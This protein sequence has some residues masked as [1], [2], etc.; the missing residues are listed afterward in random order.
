MAAPSP[1]TVRAALAAATARLPCT[2]V[3]GDVTAAGGAGPGGTV[4]LDG[5]A[6]QGDP[7]AR[8]RDAVRDAAPGAAVDW[9]VGGFGSGAFCG[10][11]D[12]IQ[13][14]A[15][16][17]GAAPAVSAG[18]DG[19]RTRLR[20]GDPIIVRA[21]TPAFEARLQVDYLQSDGTVDHMQP[22]AAYPGRVYPPGTRVAVGE[23]VPGFTPP[24]VGEPY[25]TDMVVVVASQRP[26]FAQPRP[27]TEPVA[28]YAKALSEAI[29][30][31]LARHERV[32]ATAFVLDT[33]PR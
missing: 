6:G 23:P 4:V 8:L 29:A 1:A 26:L 13:P 7:Q 22:S 25:G 30:A 11:L 32:A 10:A 27:E 33:G 21:T 24:T 14:V 9:R 18:L 31:A 5:V 17:F 16:G 12:A 19:G 2:L 28:A 20:D 15:A 3:S